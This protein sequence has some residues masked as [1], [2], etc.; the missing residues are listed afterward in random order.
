MTMGSKGIEILIFGIAVAV[1]FFIVRAISTFIPLSKDPIPEKSA[2][3]LSTTI[4]GLCIP[5]ALFFLAPRQ[6][7]FRPV[8]P[9]DEG[10]MLAAAQQAERGRRL[11]SEISFHYGPLYEIAQ[12][13]LAFRLFGETAESLRR[14]NSTIE[15]LTFVALY[16]LAWIGLR[17][18][19]L[20]LGLPLV[21]LTRYDLWV[22]QRI[23]PATLALILLIHGGPRALFLAGS[24]ISLS[25]FYSMETGLLL[26]CSWVL[27]TILEKKE[28]RWA[29][30]WTAMGMGSVG[31]PVVLYFIFTGRAEA[32]FEHLTFPQ[33]FLSI[34]SRP[35]PSIV[36][37]ITHVGQGTW[38]YF[39]AF[40]SAAILGLRNGDR[41]LRWMGAAGLGFFAIALSRSDYDHWIK[42]VPFLVPGILLTIDRLLGEI[43][44][45]KRWP[46]RIFAG[47][48]AALLIHCLTMR[49]DVWAL[50]TPLASARPWSFE[51]AKP[52]PGLE[53]LGRLTVHGEASAYAAVTTFVSSQSKPGDRLY[54]LS[55]EALFYFLADRLSPTR[56]LLFVVVRGPKRVEKALIDLKSA[57]PV[58]IVARAERDGTPV[59]TP[60]QGP[61]R[62]WVMDHYRVALRAD[63][64][65]VFEREKGRNSAEKGRPVAR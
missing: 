2:S 12:P 43:R 61:I 47:G 31:V 24:L 8:N 18:P 22:P 26:I 11:Y 28:H 25:Y 56:Y 38:W 44:A 51:P 58:C 57:P 23:L 40:L 13:A 3:R 62:D 32:F 19:W 36:H 30:R 37:A 10:V 50:A 55:D 54:V 64:F 65:V 53:R 17:Y 7:P 33:H 27:F 41:S 52:M 14:L 48:M 5:V 35:A 6:D 4:Y 20:A 15:G 49:S 45:G 63:P 46:I 34:A 60:D 59:V 39:P 42:G 21:Y 1:I 29:Q 16:L 9:V